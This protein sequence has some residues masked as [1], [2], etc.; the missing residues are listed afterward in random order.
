[1]D[2]FFNNIVFQKNAVEQLQQY[3][4]ENYFKKKI[5]CVF[6]SQ[7]KR[8]HA[9]CVI[10]VLNK[11]NAIFNTIVLNRNQF[12]NVEEI[13]EIYISNHRA[14]DLIL[15]VGGGECS[16]AVKLLAKKFFC[17][18][19]F[20]ASTFGNMSFFNNFSVIENGDK[21]QFEHA[22]GHVKVFIEEGWVKNF[23]HK[24]VE[25]TEKFL[26]SLSGFVED[27][28]FYQIVFGQKSIIDL[29][30]LLN[31]LTSMMSELSNLKND[32]EVKL[33]LMDYVIDI[34]FVLKDVQSEFFNFVKLAN[35][36][37]RLLYKRGES[38]SFCDLCYLSAQTLQK[39]YQHFYS[40]KNI[41]LFEPALP[42]KQCLITSK[43]G[44][45]KS[46][47]KN[48][49]NKYYFHK[50]KLFFQKINATKPILLKFSQNLRNDLFV[51]LNCY[52]FKK[53]TSEDLFDSVKLL[54]RLYDCG[55][56]LSLMNQVG[57]LNA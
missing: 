18:S 4:T 51:K 38:V 2:K 11:S 48:E 54:S 40:I 39:F 36:L 49:G 20:L 33:R 30:E 7:A 21:V 12:V 42:D 53:V 13:N 55:M 14:Y 28:K 46:S 56:V 34:S 27:L 43:F 9:S 26:L 16:D 1:M 6:S 31:M 17:P 5:L 37:N 15:G 50:N 25:Q 47:L 32:D 10:N 8:E 3:L 57:L 41:Q 29:D 44:I 24:K 22:F 19:L 45:R 35:L 52:S 23:D